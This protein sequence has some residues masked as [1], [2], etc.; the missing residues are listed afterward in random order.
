MKFRPTPINRAATVIPCLLFLAT[1]VCVAGC[2]YFNWPTIVFQP[3]YL[4]M[5]AVAILI[6]SRYALSHFEYGLTETTPK[7]PVGKFQVFMQR[8]KRIVPYCDLDLSMAKEL[9]SKAEDDRRKKEKSLPDFRRTFSFVQNLFARDVYYLYI[10]F[11][12]GVVR[13]KLEIN[14][15]V[16]LAELRA[17]IEAAKTL[18]PR[19]EDEEEEEEELVDLPLPQDFTQENDENATVD[20]DQEEK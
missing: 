8:G 6:L 15:E 7:L 20:P 3:L 19:T 10:Q 18:P 1:A 11:R 9:L 5:M 4:L 14:N 12:D 13:L 17:R 2:A 16:F